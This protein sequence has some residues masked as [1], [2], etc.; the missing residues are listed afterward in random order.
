MPTHA[1]WTTW[2]RRRPPDQPATRCHTTPRNP[3]GKPPSGSKRTSLP[4][5]T[6]DP[7]RDIRI[8]RKSLTGRDHPLDLEGPDVGLIEKVER[9][10]ENDAKQDREIAAVK[11]KMGP[12]TPIE[13]AISGRKLSAR[14]LRIASLVGA[15][16]AAFVMALIAALRGG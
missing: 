4:P 9:L 13:Q 1:L 8:V 16:L 15:G 14:A 3:S 6:G 7:E 5:G 10:E 2:L 12:G 11:K